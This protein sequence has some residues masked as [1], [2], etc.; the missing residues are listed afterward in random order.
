MCSEEYLR[1]PLHRRDGSLG[2]YA[3]IDPADAALAEYRWH[4][5]GGGYAARTVRQDGR[6]VSIK[7]H[8]VILGLAYGDPREGDHINHDELDCRRSNLR[9]LT[10]AQ[11]GQHR[12]GANQGSTSRFRG[13]SWN[14]RDNKWQV[15]VRVNGRRHSLG[16]FSRE[17]DAAEAA[18]AF[19]AIHF[20]HSREVTSALV[21]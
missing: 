14:A 6:R 7:L 16:Y 2:A 20:P 3:L 13:V 1:I 15:E 8:R 10:H 4:R 12:R 9:I 11:N 5:D 17:E 18:R 21:P 19:R